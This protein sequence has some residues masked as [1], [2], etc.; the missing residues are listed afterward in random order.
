M[1]THLSFPASRI[2][3]FGC[4]V[5]SYINGQTGISCIKG[6]T[7]I[8]LIPGFRYINTNFSINDSPANYELSS[9]Q[10]RAEVLQKFSIGFVFFIF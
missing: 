3:K 8:S 4:D 1:L 9:I 5:C 7:G 6:Q 2:W 10:N